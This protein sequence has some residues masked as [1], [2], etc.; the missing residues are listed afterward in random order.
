MSSSWRSD[1][2]SSVDFTLT[3]TAQSMTNVPCTRVSHTSRLDT[4][5]GWGSLRVPATGGGSL[6]YPVLL[7]KRMSV[8][9][10]SFYMNG[11]PGSTAL[12][13]AFGLSQ[14]M[15]TTTNRYLFWRE[16]ARYPLLM[17]NF[18]SNNFTTASSAYYDTDVAADPNYGIAEEA[19][20]SHLS[21]Y[22]NPNNG[23]F[24]VNY[25]TN[26]NKPCKL[27]VFNMYGQ[28][29]YRNSFTGN[30]QRQ[31]SIGELGSGVYQLII[32]SD[33][34]NESAKFVVR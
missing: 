19:T 20:A 13:S 11:V 14:N 8:Q 18:G 6:A 10:D 22:P 21:V 3:I 31:L 2:T 34:G 24:I 1:F 17:V 30:F 15:A 26:S 5:I 29:V 7:I 25:N 4:V 23:Q 9:R 32:S 27:S 16:N 12:L 33:Q 28:E